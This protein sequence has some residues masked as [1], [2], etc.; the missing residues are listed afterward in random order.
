MYENPSAANA[1]A[2]QMSK[3]HSRLHY[4]RTNWTRRILLEL[5][6]E[7]G[8][9]ELSGDALLIVYCTVCSSTVQIKRLSGLS[10]V[11]IK[12]SRLY[13]I[14]MGKNKIKLEIKIKVANI[15]NITAIDKKNLCS[16]YVMSD[17]L[18]L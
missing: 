14:I 4:I 18:W 5:D 13:Q 3:Y 12:R 6:R 1:H 9:F 17:L 7:M 2:W 10:G 11:Q 8:L 15:S 16:V